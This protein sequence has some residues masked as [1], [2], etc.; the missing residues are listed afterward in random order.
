MA[1]SNLVGG[2][3]IINSFFGVAQNASVGVT[4][5]AV[6]YLVVADYTTGA[7]LISKGAD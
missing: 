7:I 1:F 4:A 3:S 2:F 6:F 5:F